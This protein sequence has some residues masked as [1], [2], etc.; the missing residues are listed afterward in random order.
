MSTFNITISLYNKNNIV[1]SESIEANQIH[2]SVK[3][4]IQSV[5]NQSDITEVIIDKKSNLDDFVNDII[6][7]IENNQ[8]FVTATSFKEMSIKT[9]DNTQ[10]SLKE[11]A[12]T[13]CVE[14]TL[15]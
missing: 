14:T 1:K 2:G 3:T 8:E 10:I 9:S 12:N 15:C 4:L 11:Y 7:E 5:T 6:N 13:I